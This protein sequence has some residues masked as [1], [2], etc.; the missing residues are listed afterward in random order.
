MYGGSSLRYARE[1]TPLRETDRSAQEPALH[2]RG[3]SGR[4]LQLRDSHD[5]DVQGCAG[6]GVRS[7]R[8]I[9]QQKVPVLAVTYHDG[10]VALVH[11]QMPFHEWSLSAHTDKG[12]RRRR[13]VLTGLY[14][15]FLRNFVSLLKGE[16]VD[17]TLAG[18]VEAVRVHLAAKIALEKGTEVLL[19]DLPSTGGVQRTGVC[20]GIC[21][22]ETAAV[23]IAAAVSMMQ[24]RCEEQMIRSIEVIPLHLPV[25]Q[26]LTLSRGVATDPSAGAPHILVRDHGHDGDRGVGGSE[27]ESS[28][29]L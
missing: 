20:R 8:A 27:A 18:P 16:S 12:L 14:E 28:M 7:V 2:C 10:F 19:D 1:V 9:T 11:L 13:S 5:G 22:G 26:M 29:V 25:A 15:P 23:T 21:G 3:G 6:I 17:Y 4:F 24:Y